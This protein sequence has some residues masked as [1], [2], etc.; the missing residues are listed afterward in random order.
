MGR[1][2]KLLNF[3]QVVLFAFIASFIIGALLN[4]DLYKGIFLGVF[5]IVYYYSITAFNDIFKES[6]DEKKEGFFEPKLY[7]ILAISLGLLGIVT[8]ITNII[9][10]LGVDY[11]DER[12]MFYSEMRCAIQNAERNISDKYGDPHDDYNDDY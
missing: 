11:C 2:S 10:S 8:L 4:G 12:K 5:I 6:L 7:A 1:Y 9:F 3:L